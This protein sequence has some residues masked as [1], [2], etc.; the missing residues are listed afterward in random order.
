MPPTEKPECASYLMLRTNFPKRDETLLRQV[1]EGAVGWKV[2]GK[3]YCLMHAPVK[4]K[5]EDFAKAFQNRLDAENYDFSGVWF[6]QDLYLGQLNFKNYADFSYAVFNGEVDFGHTKF[7][8][9]E[10]SGRSADFIGTQ[11]LRSVYF[12]NA[13]FVGTA[14]F[15]DAEFADQAEF[16]DAQLSEVSFGNVG[17]H[18]GASFAN[19]KINGLTDF[20][21]TRFSV[22][23]AFSKTE[24]I[25]FAIFSSAQFQSADFASA[26]FNKGVD[27]REGRFAGDLNFNDAEF[28]ERA[29]FTGAYFTGRYTGFDATKFNSGANF[30]SAG[31]DHGVDFGNARFS[32]A[33]SFFYSTRFTTGAN[34]N[35]AQFLENVSYKDVHFASDAIFTFAVFEKQAIFD[36]TVFQPGSFADFGFARFA[37]ITRFEKNNIANE[38]ELCFS[39]AIFEKPERTYFHSIKN[40]RPRWF[41]NIDTRTFNFENVEFL[42]L[43]GRKAVVEEIDKTSEVLEKM[44]ATRSSNLKIPDI[45][46]S[47]KL[48]AISCRR[49]AENAEN[50]NRYEEAMSLRYMA[51]DCHRRETWWMQY[52]PVTLHWWY[53]A[54]SGYGERAFAGFYNALS[55]L[56][57]SLFVLCFL[58]KHIRT[59]NDCRRC[60][61]NGR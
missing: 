58:F 8:R 31:F 29:S 4:E 34:F 53:W 40:L 19:A 5:A 45:E 56:A 60:A 2:D 11:F 43:R 1:C 47:N 17:F 42:H 21:G 24:F 36:C 61:P 7:N 35:Q 16:D 10:Y 32:G 33:D 27:F 59:Q 50:N 28:N 39:E 37:D 41:I 6:P 20:S 25:D 49:L 3:H 54:S 52:L 44:R 48:L 57:D 51:M 46:S 9:N 18:G 12:N 15:S 22:H 23:A 26:K 38:A 13:I 55:R 14:D 30:N